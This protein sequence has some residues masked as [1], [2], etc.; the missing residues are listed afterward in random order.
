MELASLRQHRDWS[1]PRRLDDPDS[2]FI[3]TYQSLI[4]LRK[5]LPVLTWGDYRDLLPEHPSC[6]VIAASGE[7]NPQL[8][9]TS[10]LGLMNDLMFSAVVAGVAV[11]T[12]TYRP[13]LKHRLVAAGVISRRARQQRPAYLPVFVE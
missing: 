11:I 13:S 7:K 10:L 12:G 2:V 6:G 5:T 3:P 1:T 9:L 8:C 4:R